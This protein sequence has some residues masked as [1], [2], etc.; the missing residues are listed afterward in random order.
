MENNLGEAFT[1][2]DAVL[3]G[4]GSLADR[5][6]KTYLLLEKINIEAMSPVTAS[7]F[8]Y[9]VEA[10]RLASKGDLSG[11]AAQYQRLVSTLVADG[12]DRIFFTIW[13]RTGEDSVE[14]CLLCCRVNRR[15]LDL[16]NVTRSRP[17]VEKV[18]GRLGATTYPESI[19]ASRMQGIEISVSAGV[20]PHVLFADFVKMGNSG[21][22]S[23]TAGGLLFDSFGDGF[24]N[25]QMKQVQQ[26]F[27]QVAHWFEEKNLLNTDTVRLLTTAHVQAHDLCGHS[28]PYNLVH[29]TRNKVD[30]FLR[31]PLEEYY[32]DTQAM[33]IYSDPVMRSFLSSV[34]SESEMDAIPILIAMKRLTYYAKLDVNDHDARCS[35]MMFGY[36]RKAGIIRNN[37]KAQGT[38]DFDVE[39][40]P[41]AVNQMLSDLIEVEWAIGKGVKCYERA[42]IAFSHRF[43]Y[44]NPVTRKWDM[45]DELHNHL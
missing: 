5:L 3:R 44:E 15:N 6:S 13:Q 28:V 40:F 4:T 36:W 45:P 1:K 37:D 42:C 9:A 41:K 20:R 24:L 17:F 16:L 35:W 30:W 43:G 32:A 18:V 27:P 26:I 12:S 19:L 2:A 23:A 29:P 14:P 33:W 10:I 21:I 11:V 39:F 8:H 31:A 7:D 22:D 34:L 38:F 25:E